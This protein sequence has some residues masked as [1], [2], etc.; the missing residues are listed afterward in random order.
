MQAEIAFELLEQ[1]EQIAF[2]ML[3]EQPEPS[4]VFL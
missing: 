4:F 2:E 1:G 3:E